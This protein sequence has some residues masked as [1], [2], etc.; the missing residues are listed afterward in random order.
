MMYA[1]QKS[2]SKHAALQREIWDRH[3]E[4]GKLTTP[5]LIRHRAGVMALDMTYNEPRL[6]ST[7]EPECPA[8][9]KP[10]RGSK[11]AIKKHSASSEPLW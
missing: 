4:I 2:Q 6:S 9:V 8:D 11:K 1:M 7:M 10:D 5:E 3:V